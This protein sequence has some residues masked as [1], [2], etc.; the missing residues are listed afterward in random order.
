[1]Q[2]EIF[3][4]CD[5]ARVYGNQLS[6]MGTID[7]LFVPSFPMRHLGFSIACK[8]NFL[9]SEAGEHTIRIDLID[10][11]GRPIL[12]PQVKTVEVVPNSELRQSSFVISVRVP[13]LEFHS[14]S[15]YSARLTVDRNEVADL[16]LFI[17]QRQP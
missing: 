2:V 1:M 5:Y 7:A 16:P 6:L 10:Q 17:V 13:P 14:P 9:S 3:T 15:T 12:N 4:L 8:V 11:D